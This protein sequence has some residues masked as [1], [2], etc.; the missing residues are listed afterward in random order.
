A[1]EAVK[2]KLNDDRREAALKAEAKA[3]QEKQ[4]ED[5]IAKALSDAYLRDASKLTALDTAL[6]ELHAY[7][8]LAA[9]DK[10]K[11][12]ELFEKVKDIPKDRRARLALALGDNDKAVKLAREFA[13]DGDSQVFRLATLIDVLHRA[14]KMEDAKKEFDNLLVVSAEV[15]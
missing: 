2:K 7:A 9:G 15:D 10:K 14:G 5:K 11:A 4:A 6:D 12:G 8:A 13:A 3:R 1:L